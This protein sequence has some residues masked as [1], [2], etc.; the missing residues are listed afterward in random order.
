MFSSR[1]VHPLRETLV[2]VL[3]F[4]A[5]ALASPLLNISGHPSPSKGM[6]FLMLQFPQHSGSAKPQLQQECAPSA[7]LFSRVGVNSV[8]PVQKRRTCVWAAACVT[9]EQLAGGNLFICKNQSG[10]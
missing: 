4:S 1:I 9:A 2:S 8:F 6:F 3:L 10:S 5:D 7:D